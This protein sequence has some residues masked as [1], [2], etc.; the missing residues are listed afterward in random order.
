MW[1]FSII[2][3]W[4]SP[5]LAYY[6]YETNSNI[7]VK[8]RK[9]GFELITNVPLVI[10]ALAILYTT[11]FNSHAINLFDISLEIPKYMVLLDYFIFTLL[12]CI[13]PL[14]ANCFLSIKMEEKYP[15][16]ERRKKRK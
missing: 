4:I 1:F 10:L 15:S 12:I 11:Y 8:Q 14:I 2:L 7:S 13:I 6:L 16:N 9:I 5:I 3:Y